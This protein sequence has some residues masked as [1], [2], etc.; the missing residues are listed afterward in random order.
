MKK[1]TSNIQQY[2]WFK[3]TDTAMTSLFF[4]QNCRK[5]FGSWLFIFSKQLTMCWAGLTI[6]AFEHKPRSMTS[7]RGHHN[8]P[9]GTMPMLYF[10]LYSCPIPLFNAISIE[11]TELN[12]NKITKTFKM[13]AKTENIK[14]N[15][16]SKYYQKLQEW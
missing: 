10:P 9:E 6:W 14:I 12:H 15:S 3:C 16:N 5:L 11:E 2:Y 13:K 1:C 8:I 7:E 4:L